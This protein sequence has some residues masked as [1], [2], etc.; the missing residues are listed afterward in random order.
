M[1]TR[2]YFWPKSYDYRDNPTIQEVTVIHKNKFFQFH[3]EWIIYGIIII[4]LLTACSSQA[5]SIQVTVTPPQATNA[6][7]VLNTIQDFYALLREIEMSPPTSAQSLVDELWQIL[8][9]SHRVPVTLGDRVVFFYKGEAESVEWRGAFNNWGAPGLLGDRMGQTDLW[10]EVLVVPPA[11]RLEY[12]ILLNGKDWIV[13]PVNPDKQVSGLTGDNSVVTMPGF[14]VTD[15][16]QPRSDVAKGTLTSE[17]SINSKYL[18][19]Q[20]NYQVYLPVG[21]EDMQALPV[22]YIL[23]GNDFLDE[24]MGALPV[25]LDNLIAD[26]RQQPVLAVFV[27]SRE[28]GNPQVNRRETEFLARP[29]EHAQFIA[30]ELVPAIDRVYHTDPRPEAR[31]IVGVSYGGVS[32]IYIACAYSDV[33]HN[34]AAF[35]P[36]LWVLDSPEYLTDPSYVEGSQIMNAPVHAAVVCGGDTSITCPSLPLNIFLSA[37]VPSWDVGDL[38]ILAETLKEENYPFEFHQLNEGH[39]WS[40]WRGLSDEMLSYFFSN[41]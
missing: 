18:E 19:Y 22:I 38:S 4:A 9:S 29:V 15:E 25:I 1:L 3:P 27:D 36:S 34:L 7:I 32:A 10:Y 35:S 40:A 30:D 14:V 8:V 24:R 5:T 21:Y 2:L 37:G 33:F 23:D 6:P 13:D 16:S 31:I 12:K 20:V 17:M 28:P 11:S 26:H 41:N 39:T